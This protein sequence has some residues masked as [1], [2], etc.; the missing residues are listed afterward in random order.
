MNEEENSL[1]SVCVRL[2]WV[3]ALPTSNPA[4]NYKEA[5]STHLNGWFVEG[6]TRRRDDGWRADGDYKTNLGR[7]KT[8]VHLSN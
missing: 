4:I 8:F 6:R 3:D 1:G 5:L 2:G 7:K